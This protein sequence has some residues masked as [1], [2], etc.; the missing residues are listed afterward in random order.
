M[1]V[2]ADDD[3]MHAMVRGVG[4]NDVCDPSAA[5]WHPLHFDVGAVM[6]RQPR[7]RKRLS[8]YTRTYAQKR[9]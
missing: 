5:R 2:G 8:A 7:Q 6:S 1:A 3:Q 9:A 4:G